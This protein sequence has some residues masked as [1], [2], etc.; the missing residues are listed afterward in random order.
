MSR[1]RF[2]LALYFLSGV[3][4]L[5]YEVTWS[6][7]LA[8][9]MG[10]TVAAVSTVLAGFM[11]GLAT[12][13]A[14][15]GR[16]L[17]HVTPVQALRTY[18]WLELGIGAAA[19]LL[20]PGL[21]ALEPMLAR[22]YANGDGG[23]LFVF[24]RA[25]TSLLLVSIPAAAMGATF[26]AAVRFVAGAAAGAAPRAGVLY[27]VNTLGAATGAAVTGF[28]LIP[29]VGISG[30]TTVG[31]LLNVAAAAGAFWL[32]A[33]MTR[34]GAAGVQPE[35]QPVEPRAAAVSV[36]SR[37]RGRAEP[38]VA[39]PLPERAPTWI[40]AAAL[41][42][43]GFVALALEVAWT[44]A[45]ALIFGPSTQAFSLMLALFITGLG[46]GSLGAARV[47]RR[48]R[49]PVTA[50]GLVLLGAAAGTVVMTGLIDRGPLLVAG[51]VTAPGASFGRVLLG[52]AGVTAALLVPVSAAFG[53]AF[54]L[55]LAATQRGDRLSR[56]AAILYAV[57]T[58][59]AVAGS[60]TAGFVLVPVLGL[61]GTC[62]LAATLCAL[63]GAAVL[64]VTRAPRLVLGG[65]ATAAA[66]AL[67]GWLLPSWNSALMSSGA[68]KY[69]SQVQG[70]DLQ[71]GLEA[72]RLVYYNEGSAGTVSVR[73]V[74]GTTSLAIDGK[75]D[76][77]DAGDMLTQAL[78]A[79]VPLLLHPD[80]RHVA[81]IGLGSGVTAGAALRHPIARVDILEI[82]PEIVEASAWFAHVNGRPLDDPRA[83]LIVGDGRTHLQYA[84]QQYDVI[85]SEPSNPWMA[86]LAT[87][88]TRDF[89][90]A[91]RRR[92]K[93]EGLFCQWAHTYDISDADLRSV[94]AT[95]ASVFPEALLWR[96]GEADVLLIGGLSPAGPRLEQIK[97]NWGRPGVA[98][99]LERR[100][101][102]DAFGVLSLF[103]GTRDLIAAYGAGGR[104]Q[105]DDHMPLEFSAPRSALGGASA[106]D[107][108]RLALLV[109]AQPPPPAVTIAMASAG[110]DEWRNRGAM[111]LRA[112]AYDAAYD[113]FVRASALKPGDRETLAGLVLASVP[114]QRHEE[115]L[116]HLRAA[117]AADPAN[118]PARLEASKLLASRQAS[119]EAL[120][121]LAHPAAASTPETRVQLLEQAASIAA[122]TA[123][124]TR[125]GLALR[126][127]EHERPDHP[128][129]LYYRATERYLEG[130][131]E[132]AAAL[133]EQAAART[134]QARAHNLVGAAHA[135]LG[136]T[137]RAR[138]AFAAAIKA[139]PADPAAYVNLGL[140]ELGAADARAASAWFA[141]ALALDPRS[142]AAREGLAAALERLGQPER[143]ARLRRARTR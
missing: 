45:L 101:V 107:P 132:E 37:R 127:L 55:G 128:S 118:V 53:A 16:Y 79:H 114:R 12:G 22:A 141:E 13:A 143:A 65:S 2:F 73:I 94:V 90:Q 88:F 50:L 85:I 20:A 120:R 60:L 115:A 122:D 71:T 31:V 52:Q 135:T 18:A 119:D 48:L 112:R 1:A 123:D 39:V 70:S 109:S 32:T 66:L 41:A 75:V 68:Y 58:A 4:G 137:S 3:A 116:Q 34:A 100:G 7:L 93:P 77:S 21:G 23:A 10:H 83:R 86:G 15:A 105:T 28:V 33:G 57:N 11:G 97:R 111:L 84:S 40:V 81:I 36:K 124:L 8:L 72:G 121:V 46:I 64:C 51:W 63:G 49:H 44:R 104:I 17:P 69:S 61:Q 76:A 24:A 126:A 56:H 125:L 131:T 142:D 87:L 67:A 103:A 95:F 91:G 74:G 29:L 59:G 140:L 134:P 27:A 130:K 42:L 138:Q 14:L 113:S 62:V 38:T 30:T 9:H 19:L 82:S 136:R 80:P 25:A 92:L 139:D 78:L 98:E 102:R 117:I 108:S 5:L 43:S 129:A 133:A 99:D 89:F 35:H 106:K 6:R 110:A 96:I 47:A 26:P 54:P